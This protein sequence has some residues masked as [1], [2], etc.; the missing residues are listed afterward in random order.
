MAK[1]VELTDELGAEGTLLTE[2]ESSMRL[3]SKFGFEVI[4]SDQGNIK[5]TE[6]TN[7]SMRRPAR[8]SA[9]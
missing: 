8:K 2:K 6:F 7:Y 3:Y 1:A 9:A 4:S 5:G